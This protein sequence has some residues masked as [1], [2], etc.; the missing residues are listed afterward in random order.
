AI[1]QVGVPV[2]GGMALAAL[3]LGMGAPLVLYGTVAGRFLPR[4]GRW[5]T[6]IER[7][8]GVAMLAYAAWLL[9]RVVPPP[10]VLVLYGVIGLLTAVL[11]GVF[12][13]PLMRREHGLARG[14][15]LLAGLAG[16][17]LIVGGAGGGTNPL[18]PLAGFRAMP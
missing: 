4:A 5:M 8:L 6:V 12:R 11:F 13:R 18:S 7:L 15:G 9:G 2:R 1:G 10:V 14:A 17:V 16:L 3:A